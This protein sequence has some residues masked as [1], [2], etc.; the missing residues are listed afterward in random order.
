M[1]VTTA[2]TK[3][4]N[5]SHKP[6]TLKPSQ[7]ESCAHLQVLQEGEPKGLLSNTWKRIVRG[8]TCAD[9]AR[10]FVG[11]VRPGGEQEGKGTQENCSAMWLTVSGFMVMGLVCRLSLANHSDSG[12]F[13]VACTLLSQDGF[14]QK[15]FWEVGR[16]YGLASSLSF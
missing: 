3:L 12:S 5:R 9:K 4:L 16:T 6:L 13:L 1:R 11:N 15:G 2:T 10:D 7:K 8:D 14:Q